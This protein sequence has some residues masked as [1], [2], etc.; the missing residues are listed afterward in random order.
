LSTKDSQISD[1]SIK[2]EWKPIKCAVELLRLRLGRFALFL[3]NEF[4]P[5][6]ISVLWRPNISESKT[7]AAL[8]SEYVIPVEAKDFKSDTLV[9]INKNDILR[10]LYQITEHIVVNQRMMDD[11]SSREGN[12]SKM[13]SR[14]RRYSNG[15][16][17]S[18]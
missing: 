16:E 14:K 5:E 4:S 10:E 3:Y 12:D 1:T 11:M 13:N 9:R 7:F 15:D 17:A 6:I 18:D 8:N 2:H